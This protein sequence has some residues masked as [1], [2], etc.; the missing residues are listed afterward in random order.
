MITP[1]MMMIVLLMFFF[2]DVVLIV[3]ING[4]QAAVHDRGAGP[5]E[6]EGQD[7]GVPARDQPTG[8]QGRGGEAGRRRRD[9]ARQRR[10]HRQRDHRRRARAPG[11]ANQVQRRP[12]PLLLPQ[13]HQVSSRRFILKIKFLFLL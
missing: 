6:G 11:H 2:I 3:M 4:V 5:G 10:D 7:R 1:V 8:G 12:A 13:L 9:G